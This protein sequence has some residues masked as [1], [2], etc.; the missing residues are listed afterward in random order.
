M[1]LDA[2][3]ERLCGFVY[4]ANTEAY[5]TEAIASAESL[6][7]HMPQAAVS[8][9]APEQLWPHR[10]D[11]FNTLIRP[12]RTEKTP[13]VKNDAPL[14]SYGR[15]AFIDTDTRFAADFMECFDVLDRFDLALAHEPT[16]GWNYETSAARAFCELNT[17]VILFRNT[18]PVRTFFAQWL[19]HYQSMLTELGLRND[20]PSFRQALW[21]NSGLS[22]CTL[23]TEFHCIVGKPVSLAWEVRL[24]HGRGDLSYDEKLINAQLGYRSYIR[25]I[26]CFTPYAGRLKLLRDWLRLTRRFAKGFF[27]PGVFDVEFTRIPLPHKWHLGETD[28]VQPSRETI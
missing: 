9:I 5:I 27:S 25:G 13:I 14:A 17:G 2:G 7:R 22:L 10:P 3:A 23:P 1:A 20:Q 21:E 16:R 24:I 26:G 11:L 4:V 15:V 19:I 28:A 18:L 12:T 8:L 6:R